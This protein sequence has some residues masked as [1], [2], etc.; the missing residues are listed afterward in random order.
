M[1]RRTEEKKGSKIP[2]MFSSKSYSY[3]IKEE[4]FKAKRKKRKKGFCKRK[5][6]ENNLGRLNFVIMSCK[7]DVLGPGD[8][9]CLLKCRRTRPIFI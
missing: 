4:P 9:E 2:I 7:K 1:I 6:E 3:Q 8:Y 5:E